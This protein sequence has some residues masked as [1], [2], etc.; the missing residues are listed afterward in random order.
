MP[1]RPSSA[2]VRTF[3]LFA[4]SLV[5]LLGLAGCSLQRMAAM[6]VAD[7]LTKGPDVFGTDND[8]ELIR[9]ALPFGLKTMEALLQTLPQHEGL[10]VTLCKGFTQYSYA[11][12]QSEG[13]L[14][15]NADYA[16]AT[17]LHE[18]SYF[19]YL[20]ARDYG[21]RALALRHPGI[22]DSLR[23]DPERAA[24]RLTKSDLT[25]LYWTAASW[26]SAIALGKDRP[27][28]LA[29]LPAIRALVMRGLAL[30]ENYEAGAFHEAAIVL[31][32]LPAAMGGSAES[33]RRHFSRAVEI[34]HDRRASPY[35]TLAQSVS[36][37]QQDRAEF[38]RLLERALTFD[39]DQDPAQRLATIVLQRKARALLAR[40]DEFFLDESA[41]DST[42]TQENR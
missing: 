42:T 25:A 10:L 24:S 41:P 19:L 5:A 8:P 15:V 17:Q 32:A 13:D 30:D 37:L 38:R 2:S 39:A 26:G 23:L 28:M 14:L 27:E 7:S 40:Q 33:A 36:V 21:L 9:D 22:A 20:R 11:Y 34:A 4:V 12:V 35:V 6:S 1:A 29:D 18:R 31:D 3:R 16:R